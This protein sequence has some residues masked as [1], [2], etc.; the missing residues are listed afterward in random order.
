MD[1]TGFTGVKLRCGQ[2]WFLLEALEDN[3]FLGL[4]QLLEVP[5]F[6]DVWPLPLSSKPATGLPWW[7][8]G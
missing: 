3:P 4:F 2:G 6:L 8:S 7:R 5:A 1:D